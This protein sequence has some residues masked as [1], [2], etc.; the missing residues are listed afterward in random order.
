MKIKKKD[1]TVKIKAKKLRSEKLH[2]RRKG[3]YVYLNFE[4]P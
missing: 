1:I 2:L 4:A 3:I